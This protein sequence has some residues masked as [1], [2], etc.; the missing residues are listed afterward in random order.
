MMDGADQQALTCGV[1]ERLGLDVEDLWLA[2]LTAG[3]TPSRSRF[4]AYCRSQGDLDCLARD[5]VSLAVNEM[6]AGN[7]SRLVAP[8][9]FDRATLTAVPRKLT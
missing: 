8:Y 7:G 5:A 2:Q 4:L 3:G 9:S 6:S 1:I